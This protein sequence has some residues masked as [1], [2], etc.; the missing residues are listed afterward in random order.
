LFA[1]C[2][3]GMSRHGPATGHA[4]QRSLSCVN[5]TAYPRAAS[6]TAAVQYIAGN[7]AAKTAGIKSARKRHQGTS[8]THVTREVPC[9]QR[10]AL[11][12]PGK[13][14]N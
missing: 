11:R 13:R 9:G 12:G 7:P 14:A 5:G 8:Y 4:V 3:R 1:P 6:G 10:P 2:V